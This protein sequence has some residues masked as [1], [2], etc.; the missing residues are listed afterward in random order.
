MREPTMKP[1][2]TS[3]PCPNIPILST[4]KSDKSSFTL[5]KVSRKKR[6]ATTAF[7]T[8]VLAVGCEL[9]SAQSITVPNSSFES[10]AA[11]NTYP[12]VN[13]FVD[14]WQKAAEPAYYGPAIGTPFGIPWLGTAGVFLDVNPYMNHDGTQAGYILGFPQVTLFQ[15]YDSSPTHDFNATFDVG[16]SYN[17][18]I[19]VFGKSTLAP[20][21]TLQMSLYYR[22]GA[23]LVTVGST[24]IAYSLT[25]FPTNSPLNLLDYSVN[26]PTVQAGDA[27]AGKNIGIQLLSTTP[28]EMATGGNWDF[29]N[30][31]LSTVPEPASLALLTLGSAGFLISR[32]RFWRRK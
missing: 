16:K 1:F 25:A 8:L 7:A 19:G 32:A 20:G 27:W 6:I 4:N 21:S 29:D 2:K 23:N 17:L 9:L 15:D 3:I 26:V 18:T 5:L 14:S 22:D 31:R 12:Y 11:P 10:P 30:V 24:S 13:T 28:I